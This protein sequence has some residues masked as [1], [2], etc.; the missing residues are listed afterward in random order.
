MKTEHIHNIILYA[1]NFYAH[2]SNVI[3]DCR[4]YMIMDGYNTDEIASDEKVFGMMQKD[5]VEFA[6]SWD[7]KREVLLENLG[8]SVAWADDIEGKIWRIL[9]CYEIYVPC[10]GRF[11]GYPRYDNDHKPQFNIKEGIFNSIVYNL[12]NIQA[13]EYLRLNQLYWMNNAICKLLAKYDF[14]TPA[15]YFN[16]TEVALDKEVR[17]LYDGFVKE[18]LQED[19][20]FPNEYYTLQSEHFVLEIGAANY[21]CNLSL[22]TKYATEIIEVD[23]H[24]TYEDNVNALFAKLKQKT[25]SFEN[26]LY[27]LR[28]SFRED[29]H[30]YTYAGLLMFFSNFAKDIIRI[31]KEYN[32]RG[33]MQTDNFMFVI[34]EEDDKVKLQASI[35]LGGAFEARDE[36]LTSAYSAI[37]G[38]KD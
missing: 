24:D 8:K 4:K 20:F 37:S 34:T 23:K 21:R 1:K 17:T 36:A 22:H 12:C 19:C 11:T 5:F 29:I 10:Y 13:Y 31:D 26:K 33:G 27:I 15:A 18:N 30:N 7:E 32:Q 2:S 38:V 28:K 16:T 25:E 6:N 9:I 14:T 3:A 35:I